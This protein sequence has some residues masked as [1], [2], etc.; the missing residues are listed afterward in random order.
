M[1]ALASKL[2]GCLDGEKLAVQFF[3]NPHRPF[4]RETVYLAGVV[5]SPWWIGAGGRVG[6]LSSRKLFQVAQL[7]QFT[8]YRVFLLSPAPVT[9]KAFL[10]GLTFP[11]KV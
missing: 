11:I 10:D 2:S 6:D 7:G 3:L 1:S 4:T 9:L 5:G 8:L